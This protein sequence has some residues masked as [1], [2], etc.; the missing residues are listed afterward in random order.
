MAAL[1]IA[2]PMAWLGPGRIATD[3]VVICRGDTIERVE[4]GVTD[5]GRIDDD[6]LDTLALDGFLTPAGA[7]RHVHIERGDPVALVRRG[8][9]AVRDLAWPADRIFPLAEASEAPGFDGPLIRAA[10]PMLTA[11]G[12]YPMHAGWAPE[13]AGLEVDVPG[14]AT[15][16]VESLIDRGAV[17]IKISLNSEAGPTL[18]DATLGAVCDAA[19]ARNVP[20]TAHAQGTG[21]VA[22]ALGAGVDELAHTPW[23]ERLS[24]DLIDAAAGRMRWI[25]TL[26]IHGFGSDSPALRTAMENLARFHRAGGQVAY[27]TDLGNGS[28]PSGIHTRELQLLHDAGLATE[29]VLSAL[30]RA[31]IEPGAPADL[32]VLGDSPLGDPTAFDDIRLVVKSGQIVRR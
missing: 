21:E 8:I 14:T 19:R 24:D 17:A 16:A 3:V 12:G 22:R 4:I 15:Q 13:G 5:T 32:L 29:E 2:A 6:K 31:P 11:P 1:A 20:V 26:D 9:T 27:G 25:S 18:S 30:I 10:G 23:T 7:D 28:I